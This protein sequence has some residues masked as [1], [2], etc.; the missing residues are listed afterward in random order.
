MDSSAI[1]WHSLDFLAG[2]VHNSWVLRLRRERC[3]G[4]PSESKTMERADCLTQWLA[5]CL[6]GDEQ[7]ANRVM[8]VLY[9]E[10]HDIAE[11]HLRRERASHTLQ[12]TALVNEAFMRLQALREI[13][14]KERSH[15][16]A[17]ASNMIRR[18]LVDHA[19]VRQSRKRSPVGTRVDLADLTTQSTDKEVDVLALNDALD[20]LG[21]MDSRQSQIVEL[22]FFGGLSVPEVADLLNIS[23]RT[24]KN[25][26]SIARAW[27]FDFLSR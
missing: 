25:D 1:L 11:R 8:P 13:H 5:R 15:F 14:W 18:V 26:W 22:R 2:N 12:P 21:Q 10:L 16:L 17:V 4:R 23:P 27:L 6:D 7:A 20:R 3:Q 24:V 19:R 9:D